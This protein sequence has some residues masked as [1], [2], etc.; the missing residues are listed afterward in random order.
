M[1][2]QRLIPLLLLV[3]FALPLECKA[4]ASDQHNALME[5]AQSFFKIGYVLHKQGLQKMASKAFQKSQSLILEASKQSGV[6]VQQLTNKVKAQYSAQNLPAAPA[7]QGFRIR[8]RFGKSVF[9]KFVRE[10]HVQ[11]HTE[12]LLTKN[13]Q[14]LETG[15]KKSQK[16]LSMI[17]DEFFRQGIPLE[18]AYTALIESG[19]NPTVLSHAGA[20]GI[21]Q[22]MP[23]T[24]KHYGLE[25]SQR[26]DERLDPFKSTKAAAAYLKKL[27]AQFG[28]WP[29]ALAA[30]N[31]GETRVAKALKK[32]NA[33]TF[34]DL[35]RHNALPQ[36][37]QQYV[38][39][40][41]AVALISRD[42]HMHGI[43]MK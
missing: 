25:V 42:L 38:P 17:H 33:E 39:S 28:N 8:H 19:F 31:C 10:K 40:V 1:S 11:M 43:A 3:I 2:L 7:S 6:P 34:W 4:T 23:E 15:F 18:L 24:A 27:H 9:E 32:F 5:E 36:E 29:L 13:R 22:F 37:T 14:F 20:R 26:R 16:F 21:W 30:Y 35:L 12:R 41:I